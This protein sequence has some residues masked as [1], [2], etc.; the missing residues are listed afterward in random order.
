M[1]RGRRTLCT[2]GSVALA[3]VGLA[4]GCVDGVTPNC[5][6]PTVRCEPSA[7]GSVDRAEVAPDAP[8]LD[9][10]PPDTFVPDAPPDADLDAGDEI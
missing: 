7:D 6:D 9:T 5:S 1:G 10:S 3:Q 4:A 2:L 8:S